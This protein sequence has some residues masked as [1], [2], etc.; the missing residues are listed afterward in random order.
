MSLRTAQRP[1]HKEKFQDNALWFFRKFS[2]F[3]V[4]GKEG[5][6]DILLV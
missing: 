4:L 3:I 6:L 1:P 2:L 5:T